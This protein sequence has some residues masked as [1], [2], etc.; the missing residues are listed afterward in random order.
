MTE[1]ERRKLISTYEFGFKDPLV[2]HRGLVLGPLRS[3][4]R[5]VSGLQAVSLLCL[6]H[7]ISLRFAHCKPDCV[8]FTAQPV[9]PPPG[10]PQVAVPNVEK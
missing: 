7:C 10:V 2:A 3:A 1:S 5:V 6:A 9:L 4:L 8:T